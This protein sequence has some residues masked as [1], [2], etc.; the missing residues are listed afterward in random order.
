MTS[1]E[2]T[3]PMKVTLVS[4]VKDCAGSADAFLASLGAQ[5][6]APDEVVIV[7][8]GSADGTAE[9][10]AR[11]DGISMLVEPGANISRGR[12]IAIAAATHDVIAVTDADCALDPRWLE[13][14]V[15]PIE[16][17]ADVAMGWYEPVL[18][19]AF[20]H[21]MA[22]VNLPLGPD[23]V[24]PTTFDPSARSVARRCRPLAAPWR[25]GLDLAPVFPLRARRCPGRHAPGTPR[26]ALRHLRGTLARDGLLARLAEGTRGGRR[27][28]LRTHAGPSRVGPRSRPA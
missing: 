21:W 16:A 13:T 27:D 11:G 22:A 17:G 4:T 28:R 6:R 23:E 26:H 1:V 15:A 10:Y 25:P 5:T 9:A 3:T 18:E 19:T 20:E 14:I 2:R 12:N 24:D 7:D 8:G